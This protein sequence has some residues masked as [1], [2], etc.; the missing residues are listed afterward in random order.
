[1]KKIFS[2]IFSLAFLAFVASPAFAASTVIYNNIPSPQPG[3]LPSLGYEATQTFEFGGQVQFA[4]TNRNDPSVTVLMSSWGCESG[5]WNTGDCL[6]TPG[7]TFSEPV[8]LNIYE[9]DAGNLPGAKI[10]TLTQTFNIPYRPSASATCGDGR[11]SDGTTCYNGFATPITFSL[12]GLIL[13]DK[14]I[15]GVAYNTSHYGISPIGESAACYISSGGCGYD[16]LNVAVIAPP[17]VGTL[18]FPDDVYLSNLGNTALHLDSGWT[19]LQPAIKIEASAPLVSPANKDDCK[20]D[21]W[22]IFNNPTFKNQ[23]DCVSSVQ[24][25]PKAVGNKK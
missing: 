22:K 9:V 24:S 1:M 4:D 13:P 16:S 3:N 7:A 14:V 5:H 6:T 10:G 18:P 19:G 12:T 25:S 2:L 8:T 21:G 23:G 17:S 15:I 20:K 11:W